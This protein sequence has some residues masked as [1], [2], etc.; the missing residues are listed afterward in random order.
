MEN[1]ARLEANRKSELAPYYEIQEDRVKRY[2]ECQDDTILGGISDQVTS[3]TINRINRKFDLLIEQEKNGGFLLR[4][5]QT[6]VLYKN[7][8][9]VS[10]KL[11]YG[12]FGKF[13]VLNDG[14]FVSVAKKKTTFDKKGVE[15]KVLITNYK[16][17]FNGITNK[18]YIMYNNIEVLSVIERDFDFSSDIFSNDN[19]IG[20]L[21]SQS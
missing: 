7:G 4:T 19:W 18:G 6:I 9:I 21:K 2:F 11:C 13:F 17:N 8:E 14:S 5:E 20:Y 3:E 10:D 16:C 15:V 12:K 1:L